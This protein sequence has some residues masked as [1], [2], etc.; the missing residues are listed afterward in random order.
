MQFGENLPL[1][2]G[3]A[4]LLPLALKAEIVM[5]AEI[6][7]WNER[8]VECLCQRNVL[9]GF[10][11]R[12]SFP[13]TQIRILRIPIAI[14]FSRSILYRLTLFPLIPASPDSILA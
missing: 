8:D 9:L 12:I 3:H 4:I 5:E 14:L 11:F 6:C 2:R 10:L 7:G 1:R 13:H